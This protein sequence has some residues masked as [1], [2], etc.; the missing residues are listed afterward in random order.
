[1]KKVIFIF[2]LL[3]VGAMTPIFSQSFRVESLFNSGTTLGTDYLF[4]SALNDST[5]FQLT[6]YKIQYVKPLKTKLGV[7]LKDFDFNKADAKASQIFLTTKFNVSVPTETN[8]SYLKTIYKFDVGVTAITASLKNGVWAY[9]VEIF[10]EENS[11]TL[12]ESFTPNF[13]GYT[14]YINVKNFKFIYFYGAGLAVNDGKFYPVPVFG[15][16]AKMSPKF[17]SE[18]IFPVHVK[19][20]YELNK[21]VNFDLASYYSSINAIYREG[22]A[23]LGNDNTL[24]LK[25]LK[26]YLAVNVKLVKH[27][28]LKTEIGYAFLQQIDTFDTKVDENMSSAPYVSLSFNYHF[29]K[30]VFSKFINRLN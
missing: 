22:S 14:V 19:L 11:K 10:A 12:T 6:K 9:G 25:Q 15:F 29:G 17:R 24:N 23:F 30:S 20:N 16:R 18:V 4:P 2:I 8:V 3:F 27:Y 5:D 13:K 21:K 28:K 1:M 7:D 26:T